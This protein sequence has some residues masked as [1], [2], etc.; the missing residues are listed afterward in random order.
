MSVYVMELGEIVENLNWRFFSLE[1]IH[2]EPGIHGELL[3]GSQVDA[4]VLKPFQPPLRA[5]E[6]SLNQLS[7]LLSS[8]GLVFW[9]QHCYMHFPLGQLCSFS[10]LT[11]RVV[12]SVHGSFFC[13][14]FPPLEISLTCFLALW[15]FKTFSSFNV[16][17]S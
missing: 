13:F 12:F 4:D 8:P 2:G 11:V 5:W 16:T 6:K 14:C 3:W 9:F 15:C 17:S 7:C 10:L 1:R